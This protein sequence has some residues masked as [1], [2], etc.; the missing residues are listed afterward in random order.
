MKSFFKRCQS[1]KCLNEDKATNQL[2]QNTLEIEK[3]RDGNCLTFSVRIES[4]LGCEYQ[5]FEQCIEILRSEQ[6]K[7]KEKIEIEELL[8]NLKDQF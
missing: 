4:Q 1:P 5:I 3:R 7:M 8:K 2:I 6:E